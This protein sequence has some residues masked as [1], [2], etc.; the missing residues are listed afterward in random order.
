MINNQN[1]SGERRTWWETMK[2]CSG[3][4]ADRRNQYVFVA[5]CFVWALVFLGSSWT[6]KSDYPLSAPLEWIVA[7]VPNAFGIGAVLAYMT[8]LRNADELIQKI[9]MEGLAF[10]FGIGLIFGLGYQLL[11]KAGAPRLA[12]DEMGLVL[13]GGWMLGQVLATGRYR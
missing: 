7:L 10:G 12:V 8:F 3:T 2:S 1:S 9:Q 6:L 5:W 4:K 11:E 13:I